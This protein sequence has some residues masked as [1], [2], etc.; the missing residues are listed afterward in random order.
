MSLLILIKNL[1]RYTIFCIPL[2]VFCFSFATA[3][4]L[5]EKGEVI[6]GGKVRLD[7]NSSKVISLVYSR[8]SAEPTRL[9]SILDSSG[10]FQFEFEILH[11]HD[12][13]LQYEDGIAELY[14]K[15]LDSLYI[16]LN[17]SEFQ[18]TRYPLFLISGNNPEISR[19]ILKYHQYNKLNNFVPDPN[20]KSTTAY[21]STIKTR[22]ASE[23][24]VLLAFIKD[25][26]PSKE[27]MTWAK[28]DIKYRNANYLVDFEALH[29]MNNTTFEGMLYDTTLFPINDG[30]ALASSWYQYHLWQY[31]LSKYA[32][33]DT[34][35][36]NL[37][38]KQEFGKAYSE[39]L[40]K[41]IISEKPDF[42]RDLMCYQILFALSERAYSKFL[43]LM[44]E[45]ETYLTNKFLIYF[46]QEKI[47]KNNQKI[48]S[49]SLFETESKKEQE[50][51][52]DFMK[53]I[54][55][56][57]EGKV[58]YIDVWATWCGPCRSEVPYAINL[59][60]Y[61]K[62]QP[63][64]FV[65]LCLASD[66]GAWKEAIEKQKIVGENYFFDKDQSKILT[67]KLKLNGFPTYIIVDKNGR[68][69]DMQA[70]RPSSGS[71]VRTRLNE[72]LK[73]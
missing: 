71:I 16:T 9:T 49:I 34:T 39:M 47:R 21:L 55:S 37:F 53:S 7:E 72:L 68:I 30:N 6:I 3:Q 26:H 40:S 51:V 46:L 42:G 50:I 67:Q 2:I 73:P 69:I 58:L 43:S 45:V 28:K 25:Y 20:N 65:N 12:I 44:P 22:L 8:L 14:V 66:H 70:P 64:R 35:I 29:S 23:D 24:S 33:N 19:S 27:F 59:H 56:K 62:D 31:T 13:T 17:S 15:P 38:K 5:L 18:K 48:Y 4:N 32:R 63:I 52:G 10:Q 11:P 57:N 1:F 61:F 54:I 60:N 41:I 36:Q